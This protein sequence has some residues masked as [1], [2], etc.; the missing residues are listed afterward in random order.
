MIIKVIVGSIVLWTIAY[1]FSGLNFI[2]LSIRIS[3]GVMG[4]LYLLLAYY[5]G[6]FILALVQ[7]RIN[8]NSGFGLT[9][10]INMIILLSFFT[11]I[12][13][14]I[15]LGRLPE[16]KTIVSK[17]MNDPIQTETNREEFYYD[18]RDSKLHVI[19]L[20]DYELWGLVVTKNDITKWYNVYS[21]KDQAN[22]LD[23]CV[24]WG[25]N[26]SSGVYNKVK[27]KSGEWTCYVKGGN[28]SY[29][30]SKKFKGTKLSN[31]H[32]LSDDREVQKVINSIEIG[33]Q[34]HIKGS[35]VAYGEEG[36]ARQYYRSSS[37][38]RTD[39]RNGA[40]EVLF[41]D[42]IKILK[43]GM[44]LTVCSYIIKK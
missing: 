33:D 36:S 30:D 6:H 27:F 2:Y 28:T 38:V 12:V 16:Q 26:I 31:N 44:P 10:V 37:L 35:L 14:I 41:V 8:S 7:N 17:L 19:P 32:L 24:V 29:E 5:I 1:Y 9:K 18:Y 20:A 25:E 21:D 22:M 40:C 4:A 15:S 23:I 42:D 11:Y 43:K 3:F 39:T 13:I 34:I